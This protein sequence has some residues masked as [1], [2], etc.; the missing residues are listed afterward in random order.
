RQDVL[1]AH[2]AYIG[3]LGG[4]SRAPRS[5]DLPI[6]QPVDQRCPPPSSCPP[7]ISSPTAVSILPTICNRAAISPPRRICSPRPPISPPALPRHGLRSARC[8]SSLATT[9]PRWRRF[10]A[11][12][13]PIPATPAAPA[14]A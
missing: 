6:R 1:R 8:A 13:R 3:R 4:G 11:R 12:G 5:R 10:A 7:A 14:C 9:K 2:L